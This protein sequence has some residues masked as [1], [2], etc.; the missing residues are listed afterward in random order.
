MKAKFWIQ[1][2]NLPLWCLTKEISENIRGTI[3]EVEEAM[4]EEDMHGGNFIWVRVTVD[5]SQP[6]C[7]GRCVAID[8][9]TEWW[10]PL[11]Y[12]RLPNICLWCGRVTHNDKNCELWVRSL[13][14]GFVPPSLILL[15]TL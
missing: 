1:P 15:I 9:D 4:N 7:R 8:K 11:K 12:E 10:I 5:I 13:D 6:L 2:Q 3:G 14:P